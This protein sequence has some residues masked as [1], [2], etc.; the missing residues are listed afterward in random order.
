MTVKLYELLEVFNCR[1]K[2]KYFIKRLNKNGNSVNIG[3]E[4]GVWD[5][6]MKILGNLYD[7]LDGKSIDIKRY[8]DLLAIYIRKSPISDIPQT[9]NSVTI[10]T[11]GNIRSQSPKVVFAIGAVENVFPAQAGPVGIFT[12][13]ERRYLRDEQGEG[14]A[15]PLYDSVFGASLKEKM[16]VYTTLSAP[17]EKLYVSWYLQDF[18]GNGCEPSVI[19]REI[20]SVLDG[21]DT[22]KRTEVT[23]ENPTDGELFFTERQAFDVCAQLWNTH[24]VR[25]GTLKNYFRGSPRY[26]DRISAIER[27]VK[28]ESFRLKN[29]GTIR[30]LYGSPLRLSNTKINLFAKCKFSYFCQYGLKAYPLKKADMDSGMYGS[31]VH[32]V[33]ERLFKN[34]GTDTLIKMNE[35]ELK[36]AVDN[37]VDEYILKIGDG[38]ER[39]NRFNAMCGK[40][41]RNSFKVLMRMCEQFRKDK[42]RPVDFEVRIGDGSENENPI[43]FYNLDIPGVGKILVNGIV[44]RIDT[45]EI[46]GKKYVRIIDYKTGTDK[47]EF[48]NIA[49]GINIQMFIYLSAILRNGSG[50]YGDGKVL[51]PAGVLYVPSTTITEEGEANSKSEIERAVKEQNKGFKMSGLLIDNED[52]L[53]SMEEGLKGEFIPAQKTKTSGVYSKYS[54]IVSEEEFAK[55]LDYVDVCIKETGME[56]YSGNI[57][58]MPIRKACEY[59]DYSSVCRFEKGSAVTDLPKYGKQKLLNKIN[60]YFGKSEEEQK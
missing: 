42:F 7:V 37:A 20:E 14:T 8:A 45:A 54:S 30:K 18:G 39:S 51:L 6:V 46:N 9:I 22:Y 36:A 49:N 29:N 5:T 25:S 52:V 55:I 59:C 60:D 44:D 11:A 19:K 47:F 12:D 21:T 32:Y 31:S 41:K 26:C 4:A 17:S 57:N 58:A 56:I 1:E 10:G 34:L 48:D 2:F 43:P 16:N 28:K 35:G 50:R 33:F 27:A 23:N 53:N 13:S 3:S 15:L 40:I 38:S 24:G